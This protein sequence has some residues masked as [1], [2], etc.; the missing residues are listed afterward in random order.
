MI[1]KRFRLPLA[2]LALV[3]LAWLT[4]QTIHAGSEIPPPSTQQLTQLRKGSAAGMRIDGRSWSL[5]YQTA[6]MTPDG[7]RAEIDDVR[8][9]RILR[10][11]KPFATMRAA[12]VTADVGGN[13]FT[14]KG[15]VEFIELGGRH[16]RIRTVDAQYAGDKQTLVLDHQATI[17]EGKATVI[18]SRATVNFKTG[19]SQFGRIE[20]TL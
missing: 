3:L 17:T 16:R 20:G 14:V 12:H 18:V 6:T 10:D 5:D 15:P 4:Y 2:L 7:S 9:G 13:S 19:E 8:D 1:P 11:G